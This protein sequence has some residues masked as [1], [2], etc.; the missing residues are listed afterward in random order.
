MG[1][2][3]PLYSTASLPVQHS[4]PL[5]TES[6]DISEQRVLRSETSSPLDFLPIQARRCVYES[7]H[8]KIDLGQFPWAIMYPAYG[9]NGVVEGTINFSKK[10]TYVSEVKVKASPPL[11]CCLTA[12]FNILI[13]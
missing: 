1:D 2:L 4:L 8:L 11:C 7:D 3:P 5:Y 13:A 9:L 12:I 6:P 10:C